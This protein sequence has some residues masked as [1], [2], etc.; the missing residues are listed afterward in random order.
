MVQAMRDKQK[1]VDLT[2]DQTAALRAKIEPMTTAWAKDT[3]NGGKVLQSFRSM[4]VDVTA[5]K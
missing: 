2:P 3:P 1:I 5:E 4:L